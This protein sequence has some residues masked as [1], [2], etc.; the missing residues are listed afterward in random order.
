MYT[1]LTEEYV[2]LHEIKDNIMCNNL[3]C[4]FV[5]PTKPNFLLEEEVVEDAILVS[6]NGKRSKTVE[7]LLS[8]IRDGWKPSMH[9]YLRNCQ[10]F[11][12]YA[13]EVYEMDI[14]QSQPKP[15]RLKS[16]HDA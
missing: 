8:K 11:S 4:F 5:Q 6:I 15:L 13:K 9:L 14:A 10:H 1:F 16:S 2:N 12:A 3:H 7:A